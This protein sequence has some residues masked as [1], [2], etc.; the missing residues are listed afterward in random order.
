MTEKLSGS[1]F[2]ADYVLERPN[3]VKAGESKKEAPAQPRAYHDIAPDNG[4]R[5]GPGPAPGPSPAWGGAPS[6]GG[7]IPMSEADLPAEV[8]HNDMETMGEDWRLEFGPQ[9]PKGKHRAMMG[10]PLVGYGY[11]GSW[12]PHGGYEGGAFQAGLSAV[13]A[14]LLLQ[15]L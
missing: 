10:R 14:L 3:Q 11:L 6:P 9:G 4:K 8:N 7:P 1:S 2:D 12:K 13:G 15:I 5:G